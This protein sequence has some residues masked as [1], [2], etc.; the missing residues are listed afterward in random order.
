MCSQHLPQEPGWTWAPLLRNGGGSF[1]PQPPSGQRA[2]HLDPGHKPSILVTG[3][4]EA[5]HLGCHSGGQ[6]TLAESASWGGEMSCRNS[7]PAS[8]THT[9]TDTH[10]D[11]HTD[12]HRDTHR[13]THTRTHALRH[14]HEPEIAFRNSSPASWTHTHTH[15]HTDTHTHTHTHRQTHT[16]ARTL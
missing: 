5:V 11:T 8:W 10:R 15:R 3:W 6:V 2:D 14:T 1:L 7:S 12:T 4:R 16:H 13:D 9:H